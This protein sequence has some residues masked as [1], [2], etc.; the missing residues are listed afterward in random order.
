MTEIAYDP[1][2][3]PPARAPLKQLNVVQPEGTSF[4]LDGHAIAWDKWSLGIGFSPATAS[5]STTSVTPAAP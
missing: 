2:F 5:S 1:E 4:T 3:M